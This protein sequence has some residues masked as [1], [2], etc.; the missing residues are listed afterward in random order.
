MTQSYFSKSSLFRE[1]YKIQ[2]TPF[3]WKFLYL[4]IDTP[5]QFLPCFMVIEPVITKQ[6]LVNSDRL[7]HLPPDSHDKNDLN[8]TLACSRDFGGGYES[9]SRWS[10]L[11]YP[12]KNRTR[13]PRHGVKARPLMRLHSACVQ[14][15]WCCDTFPVIANSRW[16]RSRANMNAWWNFHEVLPHI[17]NYPLQDQPFPCTMEPRRTLRIPRTCCTEKQAVEV[18]DWPSLN[19]YLNLI[20]NHLKITKQSQHHRPQC[21]GFT[22][23]RFA[24]CV[25]TSLGCLNAQLSSPC[26]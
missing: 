12:C 15:R 20:E 5:T 21:G 4:K 13:Y 1:T 24:G 25:M 7:L 6:W 26:S 10:N 3:L 8:S 17:N 23:L 14:R 11:C 22:L 2:Q 9:C 16:S 18:L 19:L